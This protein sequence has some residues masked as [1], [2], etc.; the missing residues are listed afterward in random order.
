[1]IYR[2]S[3]FYIRAIQQGKICMSSNRNLVLL[4]QEDMIRNTLIENTSEQVSLQLPSKLSKQ[5]TDQRYYQLEDEE[6]DSE[7]NSP[8]FGQESDNNKIRGINDSFNEI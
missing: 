7:P 2:H 5:L 3:P 4:G 8:D 6:E 1:M